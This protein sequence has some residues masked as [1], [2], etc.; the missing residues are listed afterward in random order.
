MSELSIHFSR[1]RAD[2]ET[3]AEF[4]AKQNARWHFTLD[5]CASPWNTK[6]ERFFTELDD[7]LLQRWT[8]R[9]WM[10]PPYGREI[11]KW[12]QKAAV[13]SRVPGTVVVALL[14]AR[15]DTRWWGD[16]VAPYA[17]VTFIRGRLKFVGATSGAPFPSAL[18]V[19]PKRT[20]MPQLQLAMFGGDRG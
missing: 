19:Y 11:V 1:D 9:C 15:T 17:R 5:V 10:N 7:G 4:F 18:V 12:V 2:W 6:C 3:P 14:P 16:W 13:E 8:G 20:R